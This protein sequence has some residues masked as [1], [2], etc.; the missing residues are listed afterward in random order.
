MISVTPSFQR[1]RRILFPAV[2][3]TAM[4]SAVIAQAQ[5]TTVDANTL[6]HWIAPAAETD[7]PTQLTRRFTIDE[8]VTAATLRLAGDFCRTTLVINGQPRVIVEPYCLR[9]TSC[10]RLSATWRERTDLAVRSTLRPCGGAA[11]LIVERA[12]GEPTRIVTDASW[13]STTSAAPQPKPVDDRGAVR[14]ELWASAD[15][16]SRSRL[17]RTTK[18]WQQSKGACLASTPRSSPFRRVQSSRSFA[19]PNPMK[20]RGLAWRSTSKVASR[21]RAKSKACCGSRSTSSR[22]TVTKVQT[23]GV[24]LAECRGLLYDGY[25]LYASANRAKGMF[26]LLIHETASA[27]SARNC[28]TSRVK[29]GM[30]ATI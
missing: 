15:A 22:Q 10:H 12:K 2:I 27:S 1:C 8:P 5:S 9:R 14:P 29:R 28:V 11:T 19:M 4:L 7:V 16:R 13:T 25:Y 23:L 21:S 30:A 18:Q 20:V 24:D 3:L 6:P 17:S 26:R